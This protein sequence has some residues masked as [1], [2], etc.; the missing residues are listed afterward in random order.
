MTDTTHKI[1][2]L[3]DDKVSE[4]EKEVNLLYQTK[5]YSGGNGNGNK[6]NNDQP[7]R[8]REISKVEKPRPTISVMTYN[9]WFDDKYIIERT[10]KIVQM[11]KNYG[12][13]FVCLQEVRP[14]TY[15]I[16]KQELSKLYEIFQ[17]FIT[18]NL[19]YGSVVMCKKGICTI[20]EPYYYDFPVTKMGRKL[21][22]CE[23]SFK[24]PKLNLHVMTTH[25]E[26]MTGNA[27]VRNQQFITI[28]EV[29]KDMSNYIIGG[30]FNICSVK[31][32]V[33]NN[34]AHSDIFDAWIEMGCPNNIKYTFDSKT[35]PNIT[36]R[37]QSRLDRI[38]YNFETPVSGKI[39]SLELI[40]TNITSNEI[41]VPP[42]DHYGLIATFQY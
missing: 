12:C 37:Y 35:N 5:Q 34:I 27:D 20:V 21:V 38:L 14:N 1:E 40:G 25:L 19:A 32:S 30:D 24:D 6:H 15:Q 11:I 13:D 8:R 3:S 39:K 7:L 9:I 4:P 29:I 17:S 2:S 33:E 36:G 18:E 42:S 10:N 41:T 28:K 26:S 23:V 22:G 31:E 16:L